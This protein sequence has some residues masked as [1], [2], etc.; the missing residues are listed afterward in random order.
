MINRRKHA[1]K[2]DDTA[3]TNLEEID[4][5]DYVFPMPTLATLEH[6]AQSLDS[7]DLSDL[8]S[9]IEFR[10][11][12]FNYV[13]GIPDSKA[14]KKEVAQIRDYPRMFDAVDRFFGGIA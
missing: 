14:L 9:C 7:H 5:H 10:K 8:R 3:G 4:F 2:N 12:L 1:E 13:K 11:Y 6:I